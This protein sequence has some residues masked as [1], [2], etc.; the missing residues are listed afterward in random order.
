VAIFWIFE[1]DP[2]TALYASG[3]VSFLDL[4]AIQ[5]VT[6]FAATITK[7]RT[8]TTN[9]ATPNTRSFRLSAAAA[10]AAQGPQIILTE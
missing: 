3:R 1:I 5:R 9:N 8:V 7:A 10:L 6:M 2:L 4:N